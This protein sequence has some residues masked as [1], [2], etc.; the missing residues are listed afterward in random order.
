MKND[1]S[2]LPKVTAEKVAE[3]LAKNMGKPRAK[4]IAED[5]A[6]KLA[7][8]GPTDVSRDLYSPQQVQKDARFWA[9][10]TAILS[11]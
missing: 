3:R 5:N 4:S 11:K 7:S 10:V 1:M 8:Y 9:Q 2:R 6:K